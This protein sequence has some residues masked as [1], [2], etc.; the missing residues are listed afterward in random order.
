MNKLQK[1]IDGYFDNAPRI[2]F[3]GALEAFYNDNPQL[4]N[5]I[6]SRL[7]R[8]GAEEIP[9]S[10]DLRN[11]EIFAL[12]NSAFE[13]NGTKN[14]LPFLNFLRAGCSDELGKMVRRKISPGI[15]F[16]PAPWALI[17]QKMLDQYKTQLT[18]NY[19]APN[20]QGDALGAI[21]SME[22]DFI[23]S[24]GYSSDGIYITE[25]GG[26]NGIYTVL[27]FIEK[28]YPCSDVVSCGP[29]YFQFFRDQDRNYSVRSV[30][31]EDIDCSDNVRF[32]P[33]PSQINSELRE[34]TR[35]L[36]ITQPNNPTGEFYP[37]SELEEILD[38]AAERGL[39]IVDD[40]AFEELAL[41]GEREKFASVAQIAAKKGLLDR[42]ITIK[43]FSKGKN[44]PGERVGYLISNNKRFIQFL[45]NNMIVQRD[46]PSNLNLGMIC[47]DCVLRYIE[48][49]M[50]SGMD[51][52]TALSQAMED[53][54]PEVFRSI[55]LPL[56]ESL[57]NSYL[58]QRSLDMRAYEEGLKTVK[59]FASENPDIVG[60]IS[61]TRSAYNMLIRINELPDNLSIFDTA[62]NLFVQSGVETQW[63]QNFGM[64]EDMG[65]WLRITFSSSE[66]Y[67]LDSLK[68]VSELIRGQFRNSLIR[69]NIIL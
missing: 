42:V 61:Q 35:V 18:A 23:Q 39:L 30:V 41:P 15:A 52:S 38:I 68:R 45:G 3:Y 33:T 51:I 34:E 26:T 4:R 59:T 24:D 25:G 28:E 47:L 6:E 60:A 14:L 32:L 44:L 27:N 36:L 11:D 49:R 2:D 63:G 17:I 64:N 8:S 31:S 10:K 43:S 65:P 54:P 46:C 40:A 7:L 19:A 13:C 62:V 29:N 50:L 12:L 37:E 55:D 69:T 66:Q 53:F 20:G 16:R 22:N 5:T 21:C 1:Q 48:N 56:N 58:L 67:L 9:M 57:I